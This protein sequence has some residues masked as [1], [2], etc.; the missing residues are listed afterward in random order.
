LHGYYPKDKFD[1]WN[2]NSNVDYN[3]DLLTHYWIM[4]HK[5]EDGHEDK[6]EIEAY[7]TVHL[8]KYYD[9]LQKRL[10]ENKERSLRYICGDSMTIADIDNLSL[11]SIYIN[12]P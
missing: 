9:S 4:F 3:H 5:V 8:P 6:D 2:V 11:Y 1:R 12:N 7:L 10:E